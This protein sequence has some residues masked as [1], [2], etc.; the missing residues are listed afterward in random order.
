MDGDSW[1]I[2]PTGIGAASP[3]V[4]PTFAAGPDRA[5]C[6]ITATGPPEAV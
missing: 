1:R 5:H 4:S 2:K 6:Q 3:A